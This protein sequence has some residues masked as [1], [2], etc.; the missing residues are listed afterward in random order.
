MKKLKEEMALIKAG[1]IKQVLNLLEE[2]NRILGNID[3]MEKQIKNMKEE[4]YENKKKGFVSKDLEKVLAKLS[5]LIGELIHLQEENSL[6]LAEVMAAT[7]L[8]LNDIKK[9]NALV[10]A[11]KNRNNEGLFLQAER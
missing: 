6:L 2:K 5:F 1:S 7:R 10:A 11:Y 3:T 9:R 4:Y 8:R